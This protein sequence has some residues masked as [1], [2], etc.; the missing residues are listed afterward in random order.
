MH[1]S[2]PRYQRGKPQV[3]PAK[4]AQPPRPP[5]SNTIIF[6]DWDDTMLAS[7]VLVTNGVNLSTRVVPLEIVQQFESLQD[8]VIA[9]IEAAFKFTKNVF[10]ITNAERGWVE[11][12][13]QKF[14]PRVFPYVGKMRVFSARSTFQELYP[15]QPEEWKK[16]AFLDRIQSCFTSPSR[17]YLGG[18]D[19][20][21]ISFGDS[22]CERTALLSI[23]PLCHPSARLKSIK[24]VERPTTEQL[25]RQL[26]MIETN[27][28]FI[29]YQANSLDLMLQISTNT[30]QG[31]APPPPQQQSPPS[32]P[33]SLPPST[34]SS[35]S[36]SSAPSASP[37]P[38][39]SPPMVT[40]DPITGEA[41]VYSSPDG[42]VP[43]EMRRQFEESQ[44]LAAE[45][46]T[47]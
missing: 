32:D 39:T 14:M 12:S 17:E 3:R 37:A 26:E 38:G 16:N 22:E 34:S 7:T 23:T 36:T 40:H 42:R 18:N 5:S 9:I 21:V 28:Q 30:Q 8:Q 1:T 4:P 27:F 24:L 33:A 13:A 31:Q 35:T 29:I 45:R 15:N 20:N 11:L 2:D 6:F 41:R 10:V 43:E 44:R 46:G 47:S 19:L 25:K